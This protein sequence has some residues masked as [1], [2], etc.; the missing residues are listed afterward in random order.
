V[1]LTSLFPDKP[2][3]LAEWGVGEYPEKGDKAAW[4]REALFKLSTKY[5]LFRIAIIYHERWQN[6]DGTWSD[7]RIDSSND[8]L[9][10]YRQGIGSSYFVGKSPYF[11][12][13]S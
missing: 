1:E 5:V 8:A 10:A 13:L 7:L 9:N 4:Y 12:V 3:M 11:R 6:H 2:L